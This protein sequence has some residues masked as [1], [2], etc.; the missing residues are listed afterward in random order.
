LFAPPS[1]AG[2]T[3]KGRDMTVRKQ[4]ELLERAAMIIEA[5]SDEDYDSLLDE[6]ARPGETHQHLMNLIE[7]LYAVKRVA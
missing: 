3:K 1:V 7:A 6:G 2:N 4:I 5:V